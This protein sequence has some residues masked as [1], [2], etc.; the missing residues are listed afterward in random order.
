MFT[1]TT[2]KKPTN[3][4]GRVVVG[5]LLL[6]LVG[7]A[8]LGD[9]SPHGDPPH[10]TASLPPAAE[11]PLPAA[12]PVIAEAM[13]CVAGSWVA[14]NASYAAILYGMGA[15]ATEHIDGVWRL[16]AEPEGMLISEFV[17]WSYE[18]MVLGPLGS[19]LSPRTVSDTSTTIGD[20]V[21]RPDGSII[22]TL[23]RNPADDNIAP[24][25]IV[26]RCSGDTLT[27]E[28]SGGAAVHVREP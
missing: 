21:A 8:G 16:T 18:V 26:L 15:I 14:D 12:D 11:E 4:L 6:A 25:Q 9:D 19:P 13:A 2:L 1:R 10:S 23:D 27:Q 22:V 7:C 3:A 17:G 5:T 28:L 20:H 24:E